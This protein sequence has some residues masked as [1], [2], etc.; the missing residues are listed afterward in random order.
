MFGDREKLG[1]CRREV[2]DA[3]DEEEIYFVVDELK[4]MFPELRFEK[5][6]FCAGVLELD[7]EALRARE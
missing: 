5:I 3:W 7:C 6:S 2:G 1:Q 4:Q